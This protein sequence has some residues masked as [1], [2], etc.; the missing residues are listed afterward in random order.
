MRS[1]GEVL[2][3]IW[4]G[5]S[6]RSILLVCLLPFACV[7]MAINTRHKNAE[8]AAAKQVEMVRSCQIERSQSDDDAIS[9]CQN[10]AALFGQ[11][12]SDNTTRLSACVENHQRKIAK[13]A[14]A[15]L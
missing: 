11:D 12:I 13:C 2:E 10:G 7:G 3:D 4:D 1:F 14:E 15:G 8:K 5:A 6:G 9:Q